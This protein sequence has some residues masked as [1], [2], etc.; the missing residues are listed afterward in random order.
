MGQFLKA[1]VASGA[2][3]LGFILLD[4]A[5]AIQSSGFAGPYAPTNWT[6]VTNG[7]DGSVNSSSAR[8]QLRLRVQIII[9]DLLILIILSRLFQVGKSALI[10]ITL[11]P[12]PRGMMGLA[13]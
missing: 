10:T 6:L 4:E 12:M 11:P 8:P 7:G 9:E 5:H 3:V 13:I 2:V 1:A